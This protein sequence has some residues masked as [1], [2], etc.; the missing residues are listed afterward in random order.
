MY[1][2]ELNE[3]VFDCYLLVYYVIVPA[4]KFT[5]LITWNKFCS[6]SGMIKK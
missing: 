2:H 4:S 6:Q 5:D 1:L 3:V